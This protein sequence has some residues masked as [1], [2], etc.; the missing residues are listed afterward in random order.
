MLV[1]AGWHVYAAGLPQDDFSVLQ[2]PQITP[3]PLDICDQQAV[4][5]AAERIT[6]QHGSLRGIVNNAGIQIP[7]TL[8]TIPMEDL[9]RQFQVNVFGHLHVTRTMLP[10]LRAAHGGRIVTVTSMMGKVALPVLGAYSM[11]KH[12]LEAMC[13]TLRI[14]LEPQQI[15]VAIIEPGAIQTPMTGSMGTLM[16]H[17]QQQMTDSLHTLYDP[18]YDAMNAVLQT[19]EQHATPPETVANAILH[20]LSSPTPRA[21]YAIG[22]AVKGLIWMRTL[23]PEPVGDRIL[24][25]SLG[26]K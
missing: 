3:L 4:A 18:L 12:A 7:G 16:Q 14:E 19:Q 22:A 24:K 5:A 1:Q 11:T 17:A 21:R 20:A 9:Q 8:E 26:I 23:A 25:R 2:H 10:L 13:D 15:Q 6:A